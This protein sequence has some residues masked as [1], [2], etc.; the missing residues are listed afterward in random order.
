MK[1]IY[2]LF[3]AVALA[4]C[5]AEPVETEGV[6][7]LDAN[8]EGN[9]IKAQE[10][11]D[12]MGFYSGQ[13]GNLKGTLAVWNDC[14]NLYLKI[15]PTGDAPD[16][17]E[18]SFVSALPEL[19]DNGNIKNKPEVNYSLVDA[20]NLLW[21]FP[22]SDFNTEADNFIFVT[23]WGDDAGTNNFGEKKHK[24]T[25]YTFD[26]SMCSCEES[27]DYIV[28]ENGTYTFIYI[29]E[30]DIDNAHLTFTFPQGHVNV[31]PDGYA[32]NGIGNDTTFSSKMDLSACESYSWTF[33]LSADCRGAG[34]N[35]VNLW[36]DFTVSDESK[37]G[38]LNNIRQSCN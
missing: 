14:D 26:F 32:Q 36:T 19:K 8:L 7:A 9:K 35:A 37:K 16:N 34:Q 30:E 3:M 31:S 6:T 17:V 18:I 15:T 13:S 1:R 21:T 5:S 2:L 38:N 33:K 22:V 23:A 24:Y 25:D 20:E 29:P 4:A 27:F 28:N 10:I 11:E 12:P